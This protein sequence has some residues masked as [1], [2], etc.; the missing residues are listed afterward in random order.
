MTI[1]VILDMPLQDMNPY[2]MTNDGKLRRRSC[3]AIIEYFSGYGA[4]AVSDDEV[5]SNILERTMSAF[6][7]VSMKN[8]VIQNLKM[9]S[10]ACFSMNPFDK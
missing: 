10:D 6:R 9:H 5:C 3:P 8:R 7:V 4:S 1:G 2:V